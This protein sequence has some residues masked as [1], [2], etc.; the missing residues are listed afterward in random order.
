MNEREEWIYISDYWEDVLSIIKQTKNCDKRLHMFQNMMKEED[1]TIADIEEWYCLVDKSSIN[2]F[3][4]ELLNED[5]NTYEDCTYYF[6]NVFTGEAVHITYKVR[7][8]CSG[9]VND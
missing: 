3:T 4:R 5:I 6:F 2:S 9:I 1:L 7:I 8:T